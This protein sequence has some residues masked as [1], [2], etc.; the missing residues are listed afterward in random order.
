[1]QSKWIEH[2][3]TP[4]F[5]PKLQVVEEVLYLCRFYFW[6]VMLISI[7]THLRINYIQLN[8][9]HSFVSIHTLWH[10][11]PKSYNVATKNC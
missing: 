4:S 1:M 11:L 3:L 10:K 2:G 6:S 7:M 8:L 9:E 5:D